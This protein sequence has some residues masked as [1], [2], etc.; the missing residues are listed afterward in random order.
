VKKTGFQD[1]TPEEGD[2]VKFEIVKGGMGSTVTFTVPS[3]YFVGSEEQEA[4][5]FKVTVWLLPV[6]LAG[7]VQ[8]GF[9]ELVLEKEPW[10]RPPVEETHD[11]FQVREWPKESEAETEREVLPPEGMVEGEAVGP[12]VIETMWGKSTVIEDWADLVT[13][14]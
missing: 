8:V 9:W 4:F 5:T 13:P 2:A 6:V 11:Q 10:P 12:E 3:A 7:A 1:D 14:L